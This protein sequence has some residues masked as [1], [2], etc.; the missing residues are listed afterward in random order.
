MTD[1]N[2]EQVIELAKNMGLIVSYTNEKGIYYTTDGHSRGMLEWSNFR[3]QPNASKSK[4]L[5]FERKHQLNTEK[6]LK[7]QYIKGSI[8]PSDIDSWIN[9]YETFLLFNGNSNE[10]NHIK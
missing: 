9:N 10:I 7:M 3:Q 8:P 5:E 6:M 4:L 1:E 2:K